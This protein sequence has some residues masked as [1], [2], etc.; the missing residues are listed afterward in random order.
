MIRSIF[1]PFPN[2][3]ALFE[4]YYMYLGIGNIFRLVQLDKLSLSLAMKKMDMRVLAGIMRGNQAE[5]LIY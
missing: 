5:S 2:L 1:I 4:Y 3:R